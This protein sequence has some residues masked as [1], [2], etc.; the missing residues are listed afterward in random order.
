M[1][2]LRTKA[3]GNGGRR[4]FR[5]WWCKSCRRNYLI[6]QKVHRERSKQIDAAGTEPWLNC[7]NHLPNGEVATFALYLHLNT[8]R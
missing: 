7:Y 5:R 1:S 4:E 3:G 2:R 6:D 8:I